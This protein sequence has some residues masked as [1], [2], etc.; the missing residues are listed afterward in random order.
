MSEVP[1]VITEVEGIP[2]NPF[3]K[4]EQFFHRLEKLAHGTS[5]NIIIHPRDLIKLIKSQ[6][7]LHKNYK[8]F[9]HDS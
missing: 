3:A 9:L 1:A 5:F 2:L 8:K 7:K 4:N 6:L